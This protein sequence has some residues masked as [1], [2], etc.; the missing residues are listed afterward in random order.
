MIWLVVA[1]AFAVSL[2]GV[3]AVERYATRLGLVDRPNE[4]S[5][6][7]APRPRGGGIGIV[8]GTLAGTSAAV[9]QGITV[10]T[11]VWWILGASTLVGLIGYVDDIRSLGPGVRL[12]G[13]GLA[14]IIVV[15]TCG[16]LQRVPLPPP[17]DLPL[18]GLGPLVSVIGLVAVTN[19]FNFMDGADG[20]AGGQAGVTVAAL[21]W[22]LWPSDVSLVLFACLAAV[23][24]FMTR[25]WAPARI[26]LGDTGSGFL[27]FLLAAAAFGAAPSIREDVVL[28]AAISLSLFLIDPAATLFV[29][30]RRGAPLT[31]AHREH[32]YQRLFEPGA[33]HARVVG[34]ILTTAVV[35]TVVAVM[36]YGRPG[37]TWGAAVLGLLA[38]LAEWQLAGATGRGAAGR[39]STEVRSR[40]AGE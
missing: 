25:N 31:A 11:G 13:Q 26:F 39:K 15:T 2:L 21:V 8:V 28:V 37:V 7:V 34:G 32:A 24:A 36:G 10:D 6:H 16:A 23:L 12:A 5:S 14:A 38:G 35:V 30:W 4:R 22:I 1:T 18:G 20:L 19:F 17:L 9:A 3:L 33:S 40:P 29:R 27:G